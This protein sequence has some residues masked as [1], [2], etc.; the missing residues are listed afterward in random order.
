MASKRTRFRSIVTIFTTLAIYSSSLLSAYAPPRPQRISER[1]GRVALQN[2]SAAQLAIAYLAQVMDQF[3]GSYP[4]YADVSSAG[5]HFFAWTKFEDGNANAN[6]N[7]SFTGNPHSGATSIQC[8]FS[9][10][11]G[12]LFGGFVFQNGTLSGTNPTPQPNF[13]TEPNAGIDLNGATALT[14]WARGKQ[15]GEVVD[16]FMGGVGRNPQTGNVN[17]PCTPTFS[18][19]CPNPDSTPARHLKP[20]LTNQWQQFRIDLTNVPL[21]S[22]LGGF[23]WGVD[24]PSNPGG[25][26]FYLDDIQYELNSTRLAQRLNEPRLLRSFTTL[27][28]QSQDAP[29]DDFD[30]VLRNSA[31]IYDNAVALLAFL[32]DGSPDS[33]RRARLIGDALVYASQHD[34]AYT[35]GRLRSDYAAGDISLPPGWTPNGRA[36]TAPA[37]GFYD[38]AK[39]KF[40]EIEQEAIDTGNNTWAMIALLALYRQT[41]TPAYLTTARQLGNFIH[42]FRNDTGT[43][44]GFQGG[45]ENYPETPMVTRRTYGSTEHNLDVYAAFTSMGQITGEPQWQADAQHAQQFVEAMWDSQKRCYL[46][47]TTDPSTRNAVPDQLPLDVQAWSTLAV[48]GALALHPETLDCAEQ[49]HR[50]THDGFSGFDFNNDKDGVWFEGTAQMATAYAFALQSMLALGIRQELS[51]AQQTAPFGDTEGIAAASHEGLTTGFA[52]K[53]FRRLHIGATAWNVFAQLGYNPFYQTTAPS[54]QFSTLSY[55]IGEGTPAVNIVVNR[56]GA[57]SVPGSVD[58]A[59]SDNAAINCN[60]VSSGRASLRCDY[61]ASAGTLRF[62]AGETSKTIS[63]PIIDDAY[64]EGS[65]SFTITLSNAIG[66]GVTIAAPAKATITITD[67]DSVNGTNPI[68][69]ASYFV[70]LHYI[71]FL[72][73]EP[74]AGGLAF[75]TNQITECQQP[76]ATCNA[77]VRRVNVSAAFFLSIEFQQTGYLVERLYKTAYGNGS[78]TSTIGVAH[79]LAVPIVRFN[80]FLPDTQQ[81]GQGVIVGQSGWEQALE[82]NKQ[83]FCSEFVQRSRFTQAFPNSMTAA[84][85]VDTLNTNA[86]NPL[87]S[88]ERDQLV[89]DLSTS[90]KTRAQVLRTVAEDPD[91]HGAEFN[92]AFVLMQYFG[93]LRRNPNDPQDSDYTGYDFWLTKLNQ[94]NGNFVNA[95]MVKAFISS[96]EYRQRFG[97]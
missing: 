65:E 68:D 1:Q 9:E 92:R 29:V 17:N 58:Y 53:Y 22:V 16:F 93:Y 48:P 81:I 44:Q 78:G 74:D 11:P 77:E 66:S 64:A 73:R 59:T 72:N 67:N 95:D 85:F 52:F 56:L 86:G 8:S 97:P 18:G 79:Q 41:A 87:S 4:V 47:G 26:E 20:T 32:A 61:E 96:A 13:G 33:L 80:E 27:P 7:G 19:P 21:N 46:A 76:G 70:R 35:D 57:T 34:R 71:D 69:Q 28:F 62:A 54:V 24:G 89:A 38:E 50:N 63:I 82:N 39:Q 83:M 43:F 10:T 51:R 75:W 5:N 88:S 23:G 3:H 12:H 6:V 42:T 25:A 91:L 31:F 30:L 49:N 14:F 36:G 15:G 60:V 84:H 2:A 37:P 90:A 55:T 94:F 40:I 45:L